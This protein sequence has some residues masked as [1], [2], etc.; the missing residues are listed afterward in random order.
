MQRMNTHRVISLEWRVP[1]LE[2]SAPASGHLLGR[3]N[4]AKFSFVSIVICRGMLVR[5]EDL[6][7]EDYNVSLHLLY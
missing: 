6:E 3:H 7:T 2:R 1:K 5:D 4:S